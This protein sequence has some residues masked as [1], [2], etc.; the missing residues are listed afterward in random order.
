M[1]IQIVDINKVKLNDKNPRFIK[2]EKFKKLV[3]SIKGFPEMLKL[4]PV[5]VDSDMIALGGNMRLRA[6][7][8]AGLKQIPI[9]EASELTEVQKK[10]FIIK[11]NVGF[12]EWDYDIL[13]NEWNESDLIEW[14][15]DLPSFENEE[16]VLGSDNESD[17]KEVLL[18]VA[19]A[20]TSEAE[21]IKVKSVL[22]IEE[23]VIKANDFLKLL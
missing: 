8:E 7:K 14:G 2:D 17:G 11:D 15:L 4:R 16:D 22:K 13:A 1:N 18:V 6:A 19:I 9:I 23:Q 12:G 3:K 5:V 10:E 21:L 20:C